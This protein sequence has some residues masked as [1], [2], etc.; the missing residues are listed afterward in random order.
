MR[1]LNIF[2]GGSIEGLEKERQEIN[3]LVHIVN[4]ANRTQTLLSPTIERTF[5]TVCSFSNFLGQMYQ[6]KINN[7]IQK[8]VDCAIFLI[9]AKDASQKESC[10][11]NFT[12]LEIKTVLENDIPYEIFIKPSDLNEDNK[13]AESEILGIIQPQPCEEGY[14]EDNNAD[15]QFFYYTHRINAVIPKET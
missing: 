11:G 8:D 6:G 12:K 5:I 4:V 10:I 13:K 1:Y 15:S 7:S 14:A 3:E 9:N 2:V